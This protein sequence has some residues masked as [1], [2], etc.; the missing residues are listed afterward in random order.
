MRTLIDLQI[1]GVLLSKEYEDRLEAMAEGKSDD[2][3][4][5]CHAGADV[6]MEYW[7]KLREMRRRLCQ[8]NDNMKI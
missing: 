1:E 4:D 8:P 7:E 3:R 2:W 6:I 5:G